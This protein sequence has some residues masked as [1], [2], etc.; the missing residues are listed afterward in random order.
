MTLSYFPTQTISPSS[1]LHLYFFNSFNALSFSKQH[2]HARN[3]PSIPSLRLINSLKIFTKISIPD[4]PITLQIWFTA[5]FAQTILIS[6][7]T[8]IHQSLSFSRLCVNPFSPLLPRRFLLAYFHYTSR[9]VYPRNP[10]RQR[11]DVTQDVP[12]GLTRG[13]SRGGGY[14]ARYEITSNTRRGTTRRGLARKISKSRRFRPYS[15]YLSRY[16]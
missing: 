4:S 6:T 1:F 15:Y 16:P 13:D 2:S 7:P 11:D 9:Y 5:L 10:K 14:R 12:E 3:N 8:S